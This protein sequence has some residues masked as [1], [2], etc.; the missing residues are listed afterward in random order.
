V[1][2]SFVRGDDEE[3]IYFVSD[4]YF[5]HSINNRHQLGESVYNIPEVE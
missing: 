1:T 5:S 4:G 3:A 2:T